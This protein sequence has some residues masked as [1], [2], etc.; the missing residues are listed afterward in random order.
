MSVHLPLLLSD[1]MVLQRSAEIRL[2]GTADETVTVDFLGMR[3]HAAPAEDGGWE[4]IMKDLRPGGPYTMTINDIT[5]REV[6]VGDVWLCSGQSNMQFPML[7]ARHMYPEEL[8]ASN[9]NIR[10]FTVPQRFDFHAPKGSLEGGGWTGA[11]PGTTMDLSAVGY[12]FAKRL[13]ERYQVPIGL[14][15]SAIGGTPIHAWMSRGSLESFP[16]LL[17]EADLCADDAYV[18]RVQAEDAIQAESF[19]NEID[20]SDPGLAGKWYSPDYDDGGWEERDLLAPWSGAGSV[21]LRRTIEIPPE[22]AGKPATLYLGTVVDWDTVYVNGEAVGNTTYRYPPREYVVPSLPEGRCVIAM[23]VIS[24]DGGRFTPGKQHML[25]TD[26]GSF[27]L[28]GAWRFKRGGQAG[29]PAPETMFHYKPAG[30]YNGMIAP[31]RRFTI[32]GAIWYQG[33]SDAEN[34]LRYADKF[35][36]LVDG[37]RGDWGYELPFLFV[38]LPHWGEGTD[39]G[40]LRQQQWLS[41]RVPKTAMATAFDLGEHNDLHPQGKQAVG[42]RLARCAMRVAYGEQMPHSPFEIVGYSRKRESSCL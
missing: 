41:L 14:L 24:K 12:F 33:E 3:Y 7:R 30:L 9:P 10:Q 34:P 28:K 4:V 39:W 15:V 17:G 25:T 40:P 37:W 19:F 32:K 31:L 26:A 1:G 16:E 21:W 13:Y 29:S 42:D 22:L 6:F 18:A 23:R 5:I 2:W 38:E 11:S 36:A 20:N 8:Q 35:A 27:N